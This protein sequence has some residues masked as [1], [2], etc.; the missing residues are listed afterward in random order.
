MASYAALS[1]DYGTTP[2]GVQETT[3]P[4]DGSYHDKQKTD[5]QLGMARLL[6]SCLVCDAMPMPCHDRE[7]CEI[8]RRVCICA[9][10][11]NYMTYVP[12]LHS[13]AVGPFRF[14]GYMH[15]MPVSMPVSMPEECRAETPCLESRLVFVWMSV[16]AGV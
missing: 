7:A 16:R 13:A 2:D 6:L 10:R 9:L 15:C 12:Y 3:I 4:V 8:S 5:R 1:A 14:A 11:S